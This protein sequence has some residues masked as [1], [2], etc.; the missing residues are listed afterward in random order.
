ML[1]ILWPL[2]VCFC[3]FLFLFLSVSYGK[4]TY[5]VFPTVFLT[6]FCRGEWSKSLKVSLC[7]KFWSFWI[8]VFFFLHW[9]QIFN[10]SSSFCAFCHNFFCL[11]VSFPSTFLMHHLTFLWKT[12]CA[13]PPFAYHNVCKSFKENTHSS[14]SNRN[15]LRN[16]ISNF[17][18]GF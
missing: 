12:I 7:L 6:D 17:E 13:F 16:R 3:W 4:Y 9:V 1:F 10:F 18:K 2:F 11:Q 14:Q 8:Q 5:F 15:L